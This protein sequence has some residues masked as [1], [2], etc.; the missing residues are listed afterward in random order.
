MDDTTPDLSSVPTLRDLVG[1]LASHPAVLGIVRY[2]GRSLDDSGGGD[3]DVFLLVDDRPPE[4]E[5]IHFRVAGVPVDLNVRTWADLQRDPPLTAI[6]GALYAG[7]VLYDRDGGMAARLRTLGARHAPP[8]APSAHAVAFVR[9]SHRHALDKLRGRLEDNPVLCRLLLESNL[10]WLLENYFRVRRLPFPGEKAGLRH[11]E[12]HEPEI[13]RDVLR[14][15]AEDD[16]AR[17]ARIAEVLGER[18][19]APVGGLWRED[20]ILTFGT[21]DSTGAPVPDADVQETGRRFLRALLD[22]PPLTE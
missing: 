9:F 15:Y 22:R 6:D 3:F 18:V 11:L 8:P 21:G 17:R 7:E 10:Y 19:L 2:G 13:W 1:R 20:E 5:S 16:L 14:F 4:L 12:R